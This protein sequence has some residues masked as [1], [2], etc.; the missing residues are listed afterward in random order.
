MIVPQRYTQNGMIV[1]INN[2]CES[3]MTIHVKLVIGRGLGAEGK[4]VEQM[5]NSEGIEFTYLGDLARN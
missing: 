5:S 1:P 3:G 2:Y 4:G